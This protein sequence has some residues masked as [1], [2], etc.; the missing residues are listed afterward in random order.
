MAQE[1]KSSIL[2]VLMRCMW[3]GGKAGVYANEDCKIVCILYPNYKRDVVGTQPKV[4]LTKLCILFGNCFQ[5]LRKELRIVPLKCLNR[6]QYDSLE[7]C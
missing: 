4:F 3:G 7:E 1:G 2:Q 5:N 6:F